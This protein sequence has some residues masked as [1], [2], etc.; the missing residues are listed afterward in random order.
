[1]R[2]AMLGVLLFGLV[3]CGG[4]EDT[5]ASSGSWVFESPKSWSAWSDPV[6]VSELNTTSLDSNPSLSNDGLTLYFN[7]N[8][9]GSLGGNDIY[10][11]H[12]ADEEDAWGEPVNLGSIVNTSADDQG[13]TI[14]KDGLVL[15][16]LSNRSGGFGGT[17]L[18][19]S[20]R[21]DASDD[22][23]WSAPEN[24]GSD[25]NTVSNENAPHFQKKGEDGDETLY[26][27]R[28]NPPDIFAAPMTA[29]GETLGTAVALSV[30]N[31]SVQ[32]AGPCVSKDGFEMVIQSNRTGGAGEFDL[33][34]STRSSLNG[35]WS[36]PVNMGSPINTAAGEF[37]ATFSGDGRTL[38]FTAADRPGGTGG[39]DIW[40]TTRTVVG[41]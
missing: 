21:T 25:V 27:S 15:I 10:V 11:S 16:F 5:S 22:S 4:E 31:T 8:R 9:T 36:A 40:M 14:S 39:F 3:G 34:I 30:L 19:V 24:L 2:N 33:W 12:R 32:D 37:S 6:P 29:E 13:P 35:S 18:Y 7:S 20:R 28:G 38:L 26:F 17:D 1:M 23:G 41:N